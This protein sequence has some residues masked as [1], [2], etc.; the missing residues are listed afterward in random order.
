MRKIL[1]LMAVMSFSL[2]FLVSSVSAFPVKLETR[3]YFAW[4]RL[5]SQA[6][7]AV[8]TNTNPWDGTA[9]VNLP[10]N[11]Y[12]TDN[13]GAGAPFFSYAEDSFG[14]FAITRITN[15]A[16]TEV[17]WEENANRELTVFFY[18]GD[19]VFITGPPTI[20]GDQTLF[21]KDFEAVVYLDTTPDYDPTAGTAGRTGKDTYTTVTDGQLVFKVE[22]HD[23]NTILGAGNNFDLSETGVPPTGSFFGSTFLDII[24]GQGGIWEW[25]YDTNKQ[26]VPLDATGNPWADFVFE[27]STQAALP[28]FDVSDWVVIDTSEAFGDKRIP[29]PATMTLLGTGLIGLAGL[30]RKFFKK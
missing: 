6:N 24:P 1:L 3:D 10:W 29:E 5:Y 20:T 11:T 4:A 13:S 16:G 17:Y 7:P 12:V 2:L 19:D 30:R 25:M 18:G 26:F 21:V 14:I 9:G 23:Q 28:P 15:P 27:F 8:P 22:G